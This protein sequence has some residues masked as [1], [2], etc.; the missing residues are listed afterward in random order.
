MV[1]ALDARG[2]VI[3]WNR[4]CR[5]ISGYGLADLSGHGL[6]RLFADAATRRRFDRERQERLGTP[7]RDWIWTIVTARGETRAIAWTAGSGRPPHAGAA[8]WAVGCDVTEL[9]RMLEALQR[10]RESLSISQQ[11]VGFG[12]WSWD[13]GTNAITCT[14]E[15]EDITGGAMRPG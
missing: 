7:Y 10:A 11:T 3:V 2:R 12:A 15:L 8:T 9:Q 4:E 1:M 6:N 5:R 14:P 13:P